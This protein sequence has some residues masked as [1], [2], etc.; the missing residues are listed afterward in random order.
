MTTFDERER[1]FE[2]KFAYDQELEFKHTARR[3]KLLGLWVADKIGKTGEAAEEYASDIIKID[4][5]VAGDEDV[6]QKVK[7]D[8]EAA[9]ILISDDEIRLA[10][11]ENMQKAIA[12]VEAS[13]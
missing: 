3:D 9:N 12:E 8:F 11:L 13:A 4:V 2:A 5:A 7:A 10:I 6:F 1:A